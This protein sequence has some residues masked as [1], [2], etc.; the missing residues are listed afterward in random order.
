M[1]G[2]HKQMKSIA[3]QVE[4]VYRAVAQDYDRLI[5][6]CRV[7]Q[8]AALLA[9]LR[10]EGRERALDVGCGTGGLTLMLARSL[11][12]GEVIGVDLCTEVLEIARR[13]AEAAGLGNASFRRGDALSLSF[14]DESFDLVVSSFLLPWVP[15]P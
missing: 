15:N 6:P 10:L 11:P 7:G 12:R 13:K 2:K 5:T 3:E 8:F 1:G 9:E 4:E 14:V